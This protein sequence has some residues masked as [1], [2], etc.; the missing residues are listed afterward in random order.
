MLKNMRMGLEDSASG[1][2]TNSFLLFSQHCKDPCPCLLQLMS[3]STVISDIQPLGVRS[4]FKA[5]QREVG[6]ILDESPDL[7]RATNSPIA[8]IHVF[9]TGGQ[10]STTKSVTVGSFQDP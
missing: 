1:P 3:N 9:W 8:F 7:H 10:D 4:L 6:Y 5:S 2:G